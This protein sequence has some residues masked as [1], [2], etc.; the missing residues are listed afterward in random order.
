MP[1][2][3]ASISILRRVGRGLVASCALC[4]AIA[5][6]F[7][8][9]SYAAAGGGHDRPKRAASA[10]EVASAG[11]DSEMLAGTS[12]R[13][14]D[15]KRFERGATVMPGTYNVDIYLNKQWVGRM[16]V[17]FTAPAPD[18]NAL[19]C[20]TRKMISRM[21][22]K[23]DPIA[24]QKKLS[25]PGACVQLSDLIPQASEQF[26]IGKL[27][28]HYSV[29]QVALK[30]EPRG[31]V[32][33]ASW[34]TGVPA[35]LL[36]YQFNAF[37]N[38]RQ[39]SDQ[40]SAFLG[41]DSGLNIGAWRIRQRGTLNWASGYGNAASQHQWHSV[42]LY[43]RRALPSLKSELTFGDTYTDGSVFDSYSL[44]G[45]Q[46]A[47]DD[48]MVAPSRRGYAPVVR[49][50]ARSTAKVTIRQNGV[51]IYQTVVPPGPFVIND[52][53]P[54][55]SGGALQVTV[56]E[57]DGRQSTYVV[58]YASTSQLQRPGMT[59]YS[60]DAGQ[61]RDLGVGSPPDVLQAAVQHG[62]TNLFTGYAGM[63]GSNGYLNG[64]IGGAFN[65]RAGAFAV[66]LSVAR[67]KIPGYG[68]YTG[69][70]LGLTWS[71]MIA[72]TRTQFSVAAYRY[73]T[74]GY[75][76]LTDAAIARGLAG[77]G[78]NPFQ[79][80]AL[81]GT[82]GT[83]VAAYGGLSRRNRFTLSL[84]QPLGP[85][86][87]SLYGNVSYS[88][89]WGNKGS[90]STFQ[91]GYQNRIG[92][93]SFGLSIAR[94]RTP[95]G[96][97]DNTASLSVSVPLGGAGNGPTLSANFNHESQGADQAQATVSQ[98]LG[99]YNQFSWSASVAHDGGQTSASVGGGYSGSHG[100]YSA[101]YDAGSGY[102]QLSVGTSG[103]LVAHQGGVTFGQPLGDTIAIVHAPG[104][105]GAH[106]LNGSNVTVGDDGYAIV[107]NLTPFRRNTV[108]LNAEGAGLGVQ[109]DNS[110]TSV[111]PYAGAVVMV[112]FKTHYGRALV[113]RLHRADGIAVPFGAN[114]VN[115]Q[116]KSVGTVGQGGLALLTVHQRSGELTAH[117]QS[118]TTDPACHFHYTLPKTASKADH[119]SDR[120]V[121][122][123]C[124][125]SSG[126]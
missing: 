99:E 30:E 18:A 80:G 55:G 72:A 67:T 32:S 7:P 71:K 78:E 48:R 14:M 15:L 98:S 45:V 122:V 118:Q 46:L 41:L 79:V 13:D 102:S 53:Y 82:A 86:A 62:F 123:T 74:S 44:V 19:P 56:T 104:A 42:D 110:S 1:A 100:I 73:S 70:S 27:E 101:S 35:F 51:E 64:L 2:R 83:A 66:D 97:Y 23:V 126:Q 47:T 16:D 58:P 108:G 109:L 87:G 37:H 12:A 31:Y 90:S 92:S 85:A 28:L 43:A 10:E 124:T 89:Y 84:S 115:S 116:G 96:G 121:D 117:W 52:I 94:T 21:Q 36:N 29:P 57:A 81:P 114:V 112:N 3:P 68:T 33:P 59:R 50:V 77:E 93:L 40:T 107:P 6:V 11:F 65:T 103:S 9:T 76:S 95:T 125:Q 69:R 54:T 17:R 61:L 20:L 38:H 120:E 60:V 26:D 5:V 34:D 113:V 25:Q 22:L 49:G 106:L 63:Q 4:V 88:D 91:L 8:L 75:L 105:T 111:A 24:S 39:G 119:H